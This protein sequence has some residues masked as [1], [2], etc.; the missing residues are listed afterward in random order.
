M[1]RLYF[2]NNRIFT[3]S[4]IE[5]AGQTRETVH[6]A[7]ESAVFSRKLYLARHFSRSCIQSMQ[8]AL[9]RA[10]GF[11]LDIAGIIT[12][13]AAKRK[14]TRLPALPARAAPL[15]RDKAGRRCG[16]ARISSREWRDRT[17][18]GDL[19]EFYGACFIEGDGLT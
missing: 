16:R 8:P 18:P 5:S 13:R 12:Y 9:P 15:E 3:L 1:I 6:L 17:Q 19:W 7:G 2:L 10:K 11:S 4:N 14:R